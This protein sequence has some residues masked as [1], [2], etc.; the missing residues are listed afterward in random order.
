[1]VTYLK[2]GCNIHNNFLALI[3]CQAPFLP[4]INTSTVYKL[5]ML[6]SVLTHI[7]VSLQVG[8]SNGLPSYVFPTAAAC[9]FL[10]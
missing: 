6:E 1:M 10:N 3:I 2:Y 5:K 7:S 4:W 8:I 9:N